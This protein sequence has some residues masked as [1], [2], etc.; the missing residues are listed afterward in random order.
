MDE[1][2]I[3]IESLDAKVSLHVLPLIKDVSRRV[4]FIRALALLELIALFVLIG[5]FFV[6]ILTYG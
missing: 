2:K 6:G 3:K 4:R 5:V 1:L